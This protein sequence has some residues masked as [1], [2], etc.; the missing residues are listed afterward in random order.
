[1]PYLVDDAGIGIKEGEAEEEEAKKFTV[2]VLVDQWRREHLNAQRPRYALRAFRDVER[3]F[4]PCST[5]RPP[6]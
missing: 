3:T 4:E 5:C 6:A 2:G 1:M